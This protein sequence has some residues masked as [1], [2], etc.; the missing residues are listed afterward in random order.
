[1]I[2][3]TNGVLGVAAWRVRR[4]EPGV[5]VVVGWFVGVG[6]GV[7]EGTRKICTEGVRRYGE[8]EI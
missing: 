4:L 6:V 7:G 1:M 3:V 8:T 2:N 5:G